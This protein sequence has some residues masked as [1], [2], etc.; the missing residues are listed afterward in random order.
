MSNAQA[1]DKDSQSENHPPGQDPFPTGYWPEGQCRFMVPVWQ[2][3]LQSPP[4][5][6]PGARPG[7]PAVGSEESVGYVK[8]I[9]M[10]KLALT[11]S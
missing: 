5:E 6:C 4:F 9:G 10:D 8:F 7:I 1:V 2:C 11:F 3:L